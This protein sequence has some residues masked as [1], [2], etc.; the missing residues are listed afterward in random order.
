MRPIIIGAGRGMRLAH[1]TDSIPKTMVEVMGRPMLEWILEALAHAGLDSDQVVFVGGYSQEV[2]ERAHPEFT[3]VENR[4]WP[5]NNILLSLLYARDYLGEGFLSTYGDIV[6]GGGIV[7]KLVESPHDITLGCDT[8]WRRRYVNR[9]HHPETDAEKLRADGEV[10]T[11]ISRR[12]PSEQASGE[13]IGVLKMSARG[14]ATFLAHFDARSKEFAGGPYREGRTWEKAYLIDLLQDMLERGVV[15]H[16]VD[17]RGEYMEI[18]TE[19]DL[20]FAEDWWLTR[21]E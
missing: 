6:Y 11:E 13:F 1:N 2:V 8:A 7:K 15:M 9:T 10:V 16:R 17:T 12:I 4:D 3:F 21:P 5:N 19:Q 14:A 20:S 18:D